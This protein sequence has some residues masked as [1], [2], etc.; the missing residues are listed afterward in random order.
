MDAGYLDTVRETG[1]ASLGESDVNFDEAVFEI[2]DSIWKEYEEELCYD[3]ISGELMVKEGV[4][5]AREIEM[6]TLKSTECA[7]RYRL[8]SVGEIRGRF[9]LE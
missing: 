7:R 9:R 2:I 6:E 8:K 1:A 3:A 4:E 5:A